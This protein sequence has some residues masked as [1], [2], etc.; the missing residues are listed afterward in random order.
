MAYNLEKLENENTLKGLF[1]KE[2]KE[3]LEKKDLDEEEKKIIEKA[4]EIGFE[5]LE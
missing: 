4:I 1:A 3:L 2:M 5:S